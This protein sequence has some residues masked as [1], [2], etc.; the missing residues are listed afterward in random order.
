MSLKR[1]EILNCRILLADRISGVDIRSSS[2]AAILVHANDLSHQAGILTQRLAMAGIAH[3]INN[4]FP[5]DKIEF[6]GSL[7]SIQKEYL[8]IPLLWNALTASKYFL[9]I[10]HSKARLCEIAGRS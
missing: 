6:W 2:I 10:K 3:S 1:S 9:S 5:G 8:R 7:T 4:A